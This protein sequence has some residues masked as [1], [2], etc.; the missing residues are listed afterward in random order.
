[1]NS[2]LRYVLRYVLARVVWQAIRSL[3]RGVK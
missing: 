2:D 1:M 3:L